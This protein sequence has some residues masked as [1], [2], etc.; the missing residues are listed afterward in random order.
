MGI[1][2]TGVFQAVAATAAQDLFELTAPALRSVI[3]REVKITQS[4]EIGDAQSEML[5]FALKRATSASTSG[6]GGSAVTPLS[7]PRGITY[8]GTLEA[9]N[10]TRVTGGTIEVLEEADEHI[11]NGFQYLPGTDTS[12]PHEI[13]GA[14]RFI[15]GLESTPTDSITISG[16]I[17][18][19]VIGGI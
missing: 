8:G 15:V 16:Y 18:F 14:M 7:N 2:Y 19:E 10:T 3:I 11:A 1:I 13:E 12:I 4:T 5:R 9:N 17:R 6:S